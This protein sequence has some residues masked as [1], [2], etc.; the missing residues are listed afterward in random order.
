MSCVSVCQQK[1]TSNGRQ[2]DL[3]P[4]PSESGFHW[5]YSVIVSYFDLSVQEWIRCR[6]L[7]YSSD[8]VLLFSERHVNCVVP[9]LGSRCNTDLSRQFF[10]ELFSYS[11][12]GI[13]ISKPQTPKWPREYLQLFIDTKWYWH[14]SEWLSLWILGLMCCETVEYLSV[15]QAVLLASLQT[16][17][18]THRAYKLEYLPA[19]IF[20]QMMLLFTSTLQLWWTPVMCITL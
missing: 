16:A 5:Y 14:K 4:L 17:A 18:L 2:R 10:P 20:L 19:I 11:E 7:C 3:F 15:S 12:D 13:L 6:N 9:P 8:A 1:A